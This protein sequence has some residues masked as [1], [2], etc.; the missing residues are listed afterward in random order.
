[1]KKKLP[2]SD[3]KP[4]VIEQAKPDKLITWQILVYTF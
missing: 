3:V 1:M 2:Y 4:S